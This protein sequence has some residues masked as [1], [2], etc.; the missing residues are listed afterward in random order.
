M[1]HQRA[2]IRMNFELIMELKDAGFSLRQ[3]DIE[4]EGISR[5]SRVLR[6]PGDPRPESGSLDLCELR[7]DGLHLN[8]LDGLVDIDQSGQ[9]GN[10]W[11]ATPAAWRSS[12]PCAGPVLQQHSGFAGDQGGL[13]RQR[14]GPS[15]WEVTFM[16]EAEVAEGERS[17]EAAD[18]LRVHGVRKIFSVLAR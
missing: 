15:P 17:R 4:I 12:R 7:L 2:E 13:V 14:H 16:F 10:G 8:R 9:L 5:L 3:G 1:S 18:A 11:L 6:D